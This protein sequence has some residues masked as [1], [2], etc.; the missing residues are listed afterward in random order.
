MSSERSKSVD[1]GQPP[2]EFSTLMLL[3]RAA[4]MLHA[5]MPQSNPEVS[6]STADEFGV[7]LLDDPLLA[8]LEA[9]AG[10]LV[11][12]GEVIAASYTLEAGGVIFTTSDTLT[13]GLVEDPVKGLVKDP[14]E[15]SDVPDS[16]VPG[17]F[18]RDKVNAKDSSNLPSTF[19]ITTNSYES[20]TQAAKASNPHNLRVMKGGKDLWREFKD[21]EYRWIY[22]L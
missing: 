21:H 10:I 19:V 17:S 1:K 18:M 4:C 15:D 6:I 8:P 16:V 20:A 2:T 7:D 9:L 3:L 22:A 5:K 11:Q 14:V 13:E 12:H